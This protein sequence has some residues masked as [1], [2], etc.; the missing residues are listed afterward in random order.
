MEISPLTMAG[1]NGWI[2][3]GIQPGGFL[4]AVLC[5]DL[6]EAVVRADDE[7]LRALPEIVYWIRRNAPIAC[8]GSPAA[9]Y[10]WKISRRR[11][12]REQPQ[13]IKG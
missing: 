6:R 9:M 10:R 8:W 4:T 3:H 5:N 12:I 13:E 2:S 1:L 7:N 11:A